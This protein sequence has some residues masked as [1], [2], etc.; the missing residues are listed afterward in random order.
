ME[1]ARRQDTEVEVAKRIDEKASRQMHRVRFPFR[2][3]ASQRYVAG[4]RCF[5]CFVVLPERLVGGID[6]DIILTDIPEGVMAASGW[7]QE[8][9][10][11]V[12]IAATARFYTQGIAMDVRHGLIRVLGGHDF[13][14]WSLPAGIMLLLHW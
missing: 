10:D 2:D 12:P 9:E 5:G 8:T 13:R 6:Y 11:G 14:A 4:E 1:P 7:L 3:Q